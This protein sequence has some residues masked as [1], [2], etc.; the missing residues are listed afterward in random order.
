MPTEPIDNQILDYLTTVLAAITAGP[1]DDDPHYTV[2]TATRPQLSADGQVVRHAA[3]EAMPCWYVYA[4]KDDE[5]KSTASESVRQMRVDLTCEAI[6]IY[7]ESDPISSETYMRRLARDAIRAIIDPTVSPPGY[8]MNSLAD[9]TRIGE[10]IFT[11]E[12]GDGPLVY[13]GIELLI[14]FRT[15]Y[16]EP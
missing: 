16:G 15:P 4:S 12:E 11:E 9:H 7:D 13:V 2:N 6:L 5:V 1:G 8:T 3:L 10:R 14:E